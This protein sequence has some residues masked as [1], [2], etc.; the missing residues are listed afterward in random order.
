MKFVVIIPDNT[1]LPSTYDYAEVA[2][3]VFI[4]IA[5]SYA[6]LDL[7]GRVTAVRGRVRLA[8]LSGGAVAMG[9]G[10]WEMHFK[11]MMAFHLPVP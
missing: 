1:V 5:A 10:I 11:G 8:W 7:A 3:S 6:A 9:I 2:R 4:A